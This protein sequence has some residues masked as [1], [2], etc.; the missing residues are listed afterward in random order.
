MVQFQALD[1]CYKHEPSFWTHAPEGSEPEQHIQFQIPKEVIEEKFKTKFTYLEWLMFQFKLT[2]NDVAI[3]E[4]FYFFDDDED[5]EWHVNAALEEC[6]NDDFLDPEGCR[7]CAKLNVSNFI[8][9]MTIHQGH[10]FGHDYIA[11]NVPFEMLAKLYYK[12]FET[13]RIDPDDMT[14][15]NDEKQDI[16]DKWN[17]FKVQL[18]YHLVNKHT[19][20]FEAQHALTDTMWCAVGIPVQVVWHHSFLHSEVFDVPIRG[21]VLNDVTF[22]DLL[23]GLWLHIGD[24]VTELGYNMDEVFL[25]RFP[26]FYGTT[27][28]GYEDNTEL[29][30]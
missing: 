22:Q 26:Q 30:S 7:N 1:V 4:N 12:N 9:A 27:Y 14:F 18:R 10:R 16:I 6:E 25:H 17:D 5:F 24:R 21:I 20:N 13:D 19:D 29:T 11:V 2:Y 8:Y 15:N 23:E 28:I 3:R